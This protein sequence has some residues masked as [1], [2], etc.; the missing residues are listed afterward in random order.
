[1]EGR[2]KATIHVK[3]GLGRRKRRRRGKLPLE[4][5]SKAPAK[6]EDSA[7]FRYFLSLAS[8]DEF[9]DHLKM[10]TDGALS[11]KCLPCPHHYSLSDI[12]LPT[13][14]GKKLSRNQS[15]A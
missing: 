3:K 13:G 1:M 7:L 10:P 8:T 9:L 14:N 6:L 11:T 5:E 2:H 12:G 4:K 15:L